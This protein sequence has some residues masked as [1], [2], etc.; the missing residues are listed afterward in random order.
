MF[1]LS[2]VFLLFCICEAAVAPTE[3]AAQTIGGCKTD[4]IA[5][6]RNERSGP[7][8][9][10]LIG[11]AGGPVRIDCDD[12]QLFATEIDLYSEEGRIVATGDVVFVSGRDRISAER[13]E[14][15]Y[16]TKTGSFFNASGTTVIRDKAEPG[17]Q[18][19]QE[20]NAFFWGKEIRKEGPKTYRIDDGG[21]T[22][23]VQPT[24]RW[25][26]ASGDMTLKL[27]DYA[28]LRNSIFRVKGVPIL[29]LPI[30]YYPIEEDDR[31]TG[32]TMPIYGNSTLGGQSLSNQFFWAIGRSHDAS[33]VHDWLS[34]AG[35]GYGAEYRYML[36]A[37]S[38]EARFHA[39][40]EKAVTA[41][42]AT[43][44]LPARDAT[45]SY[46]LEGNLS[47]Q[48]PAGF[49]AQANANYFTSLR[50]QQQYQ[51]D[52]FQATNRQRSFGANLSG[53]WAGYTLS[54]RVDQNDYFDTQ[55]TL[56]RAGSRPRITVSR[57]ETRLGETPIYVSAN[58]EY[59]TL[60]RKT[61]REDVPSEDDGL[62][63]LDFS[64]RVRVPFT[65]WPFFT[66]NS[67]VTWRG[68]YWS[69]SLNTA[70]ARVE[71][72]IGRQFFDFQSTFTGPSFNRI[73]DTPQ[74]GF[75]ARWKHVIVPTL[76]VQRTTAI[77]DYNRI[78]QLEHSTDR[79]IGGV[80]RYTYALANRLYAKK[81]HAREIASLTVSQT[82]YTDALAAQCD[83]NYLGTCGSAGSDDDKSSNFSA[84][85]ALA[86]VSPTD[87]I[88]G[89]FRT[90]WSPIAKTLTTLSA[91]GS[92]AFSEHLQTSANWSM[93]RFIPD[94]P[95]F[96]SQFSAAHSMDAQTTL[97]FAQN[98]FGGTY[99]FMYDFRRDLFLEQ[100]IQTFY[101][102]QCCGVAVEW[103]S[104]NMLGIPGIGVPQD[105]RFNI[106]FTLAGIGTFSNFLG[107]LAGQQP[108][109]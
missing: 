55:N 75:A 59:V 107:A 103:Q 47:Q 27:D 33:F 79:I 83:I 19:S 102:A 85:S 106:S 69:E 66:I 71:D 49:R 13:L 57:G 80:T 86:R 28:L 99:A 34:K 58:G 20:P 95:G 24:P 36:A 97:R 74:S 98:R 46:R 105:R 26:V 64:P 53:A 4:L 9:V 29:Y 2:L 8:H 14:F 100:R 43:P 40:N 68:T 41:D 25:E 39:L 7:N 32:F 52:V 11:S 3:A 67:S 73:F 10:R 104:F 44:T 37:G 62:T 92:F 93:R 17:L 5:S 1:R 65:R 6:P 35:Q 87:R 30:F 31:S 82:Y 50:T 15:N 84:V 101:N 109:R 54:A 91:G 81:E 61:V 56:T 76:T 72:A 22:A 89:Q 78:V 63:R 96:D 12:I 38:G 42:Q 18:G 88:Q 48:L 94:L 16:K 90:E 108:R 21:F 51:Q 23:C 60:I 77:D 45:K 70:G